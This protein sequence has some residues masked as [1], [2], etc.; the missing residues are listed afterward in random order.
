M[1]ALTGRNLVME[2]ASDAQAHKRDDMSAKSTCT[3]HI[4]FPLRP[5]AIEVSQLHMRAVG[6]KARP[7]LQCLHNTSMSLEEASHQVR[8]V[9]RPAFDAL[10]LY[11]LH[12]Y[13]CGTW[14]T[15]P[16]AHCSPR[17]QSLDQRPAPHRAKRRLAVGKAQARAQIWD[18]VRARFFD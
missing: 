15:W 4:F 16:S 7:P 6:C 3:M 14:L 9:H 10:L 13:Y 12:P 8:L 5:D 11:C 1:R 18:L 17:S 2:Q